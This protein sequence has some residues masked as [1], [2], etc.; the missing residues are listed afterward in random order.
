MQ[1]TLFNGVKL[2]PGN[3]AT[4]LLII[5]V[6]STRIL[7]HVGRYDSLSKHSAWSTVTGVGSAV[8]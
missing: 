2:L 1:N 8:M 6:I 4:T 5:L 3:I 7:R